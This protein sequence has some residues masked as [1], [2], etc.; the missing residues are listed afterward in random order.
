MS[1]N[2]AKELVFEA[3]DVFEAQVVY[4]KLKENGID[5]VLFNRSDSVFSVLDDVRYSAGVLVD[6][7]DVEKSLKLIASK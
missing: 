3:E 5:A 2:N 4:A 6:K 7:K 1:E